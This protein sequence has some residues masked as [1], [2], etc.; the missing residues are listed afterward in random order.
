MDTASAFARGNSS[1]GKEEMVFD[2][3]KAAT[4]IK[5]SGC[6][7]ASAGLSEDWEWTGGQIFDEGKPYSEDYIFLASTWATPELELDG[8]IIPCF[9]MQS[10]IP[11]WGSGTKWPKEAIKILN[12]ENK[13]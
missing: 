2:W 4:L 11:N 7:T 1:R 13:C 12:K 6:K 5:E 8:E 3:C 9:K 10:E